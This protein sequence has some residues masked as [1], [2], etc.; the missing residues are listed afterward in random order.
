MN[1]EERRAHRLACAIGDSGPS[2]ALG[3]MDAESFDFLGVQFSG[4]DSSWR[5]G[6]DSKEA[7]E[8]KDEADERDGPRA[9]DIS[10][11]MFGSGMA[12]FSAATDD[13]KD[14]RSGSLEDI[15]VDG[16]GP[17]RGSN[18]ACSRTGESANSP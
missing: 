2:S 8:C 18:G 3:T 5:D 12:I 14:S 16:A 9:V 6:A 1:I 11:P 13:S 7:R 15:E 17:A 4:A 10:C